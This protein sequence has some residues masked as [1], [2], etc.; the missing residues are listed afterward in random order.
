M[1]A[2]FFLKNCK[3]YLCGCKVDLVRNGEKRREVD[4]HNAADFAE[5]L[6]SSTFF[7]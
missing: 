6:H 3:V 2:V 4:E 7:R 1:H 5:G